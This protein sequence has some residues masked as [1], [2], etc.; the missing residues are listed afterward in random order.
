MRCRLVAGTVGL[1]CAGVMTLML[2]TPAEANRGPS[3]AAGRMAAQDVAADCEQAAVDAPRGAG[4]L[5]IATDVP[6]K[7]TVAPGDDITVTLT[8]DP[9]AWSGEEL[10]AALACVQVKGGLDHNLSAGERPTANDGSMEY[11]LHVPGNIRP[12]CDICVQG[13]LIGTAA[14]GGP[15]MVTSDKRCFM[16]GPPRPPTTTPPATTPPATTPVT[17]T[18]V[19]GAPPAPATTTTTAPRVPTEVGGITATQPTPAP[20]TPAPGPAPAPAVAPVAE[21][22]RTGSPLTALAAAGGGLTLTFGGFAIM[23]GAGGRTRRRTR[24]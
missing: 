1:G 6:D 5:T 22:P 12:D 8:W 7:A 10:D 13:F 23:G 3:P 14:G 17:T 2:V 4:G 16:S 15:D 20:L 21:L 9:K 19:T 24:N 11:V 18:P